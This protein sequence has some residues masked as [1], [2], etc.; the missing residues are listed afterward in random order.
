M[1][2]VQQGLVD[3]TEH[4]SGE[5]E[6]SGSPPSSLPSGGYPSGGFHSGSSGSGLGSGTTSGEG[7]FAEGG[8]V[9]LLTEEGMMEITTQ[10]Q[11]EQGRGVV[12][13]SGQGSGGVSGGGSGGESD[14]HLHFSGSGLPHQETTTAGFSVEMAPG[15]TPSYPG[16]QE[17][18]VDHTEHGQDLEV[19]R[20]A[21]GGPT[22]EAYVTY[23]APSVQLATP[24]VVEPPAVVDGK[25]LSNI[26]NIRP[27][28]S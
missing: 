8:D 15:S 16:Y 13:F 28:S 24:G 1:S 17:S 6:L 19:E 14:S 7:S 9:V 23:T 27:S 25:H 26:I 5:Q 10:R 2:F 18:S 22:E 4:S 12:E 3:L 21:R 11:P 20:E